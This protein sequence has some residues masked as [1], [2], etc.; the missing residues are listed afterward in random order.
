MT[1][2]EPVMNNT[3]GKVL[4][5]VLSYPCG[6]VPV[7]LFRNVVIVYH[8]K[9]YF[10]LPI[11]G[12]QVINH[13]FFAFSLTYP[14]VFSA[15]KNLIANLP[16]GYFEEEI[17]VDGFVCKRGEWTENRWQDI[18]NKRFFTERFPQTRQIL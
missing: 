4:R 14:G 12:N 18:V 2:F 16:E 13:P 10:E 17:E 11:L 8:N 1:I 5:G 7:I 3:Y 15:V 9:R 6:P